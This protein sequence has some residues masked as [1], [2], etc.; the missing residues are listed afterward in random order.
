MINSA[1]KNVLINLALTLLAA[2]LFSLAHPGFIDS[3]GISF[4]GFVTLIPVFYITYNCRAKYI[5]IYG[6]IFGVLDYV[7]FVYWFISYAWFF[8]AIIASI[9]GIFNAI[10]FVL[11]R[12]VVNFFEKNRTLIKSENKWLNDNLINFFIAFSYAAVWVLY[13]YIKHLGF[14]GLSYGLLGYSQWRNTLLL[15]SA[16]F[17]GVWIVSFYLAFFSAA[18]A[19]VIKVFVE[20]N[21]SKRTYRLLESVRKNEF[22]LI[23]FVALSITMT[24]YGAVKISE[25]KNAAGR[26]AEIIAV[27]NNCDPWLDGIQNYEKDVNNLKKLTEKALKENPEAQLVVWPETAVVSPIVY[28]YIEKSDY[29]RYQMITK[30]LDFFN[31]KDCAFITGN[32][33]SVKRT[34]YYNDD[35]NTALLFDSKLNNVTPPDP[36]VY[37]KNHLVPFTEYFPYG[38]IFPKFYQILLKGDTHLW[39]P[40]EEATVFE[41]RGLRFSTPICF[42][43]TF[44]S[45][46]RRFFVENE[47]GPD[48]FINISNDAWAYNAACQ[49]QHL[50]MAVFRSAESRIP[51]V[52]STASGVTCHVDSTGKV[53]QEASSFEQTYLCARVKIKENNTTS[54]YN[55][56]GDFF[57]VI[58]LIL[59]AVLI[60]EEFLRRRI[61]AK[62]SENEVK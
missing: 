19:S 32:Q 29:P 54:F 51:S 39:T 15:Q 16:A 2:F 38:N 22:V 50:A 6:F 5:W 43:D 20:Q 26:T 40:G 58:M 25:E 62:K 42:E 45:L 11:L 13:E 57:P 27:Q 8:L 30:L 44:G 35:Y 28:N 1:K 18:A 24:I 23:V 49:Y 55:K 52:R 21:D 10:V 47:K 53:V 9:Y 41:S 37:E 14:L 17:G 33:H 3:R 4:F 7:L 61:V 36:V 31:S 59:F 46:T 34:P 12:Y 60:C 48:V 56:H